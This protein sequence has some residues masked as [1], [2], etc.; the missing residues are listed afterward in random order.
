[1]SAKRKIAWLPG[2]GVGKDVLDAVKIVLDKVGLDAEYEEGDIGWEFWKTEGD[3]LPQRTID[4]LNRCDA[5]IFGAITSKPVKKAE[6]ELA[7]ELRG[8]GYVYRSPIV[9]MR[10]HFDLYACLRPTKA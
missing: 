3:P 4:L 10:Q 1:M 8:K 6:E 9:R 5:A 7:P 2:D